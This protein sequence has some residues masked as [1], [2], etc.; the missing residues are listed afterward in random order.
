MD[1]IT[2]LCK[3]ANIQ[4]EL[5]STFCFNTSIKKR[6]DLVCNINNKD[7]LIDVTTIDANNP[8]NGFIL[9]ADNNNPSKG[10]VLGADL[11]LSYFPG[12]CGCQSKK[13]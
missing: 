11:A 8:S 5:E 3:A 12:C 6:I 10:F 2:K 9:G 7:I 4:V 1:E 13:I